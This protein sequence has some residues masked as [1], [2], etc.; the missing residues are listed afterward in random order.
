MLRVDT[1]AAPHPRLLSA[2]FSSGERIKNNSCRD[3]KMGGLKMKKS[4][5][6]LEIMIV[7]II[8]SVLATIGYPSFLNA[9]ESSKEKICETNLKT[10]KVSLDSYIMDHDAMPATL[11]QIPDDYFKRAYKEV[12]KEEGA[13][14]IRLARFIIG[15]NE[16][17]NAYAEPGLLETLAGG[18]RSLMVCPSSTS[19]E[20]SYGFND[21]L[22]NLTSQQYGRIANAEILVADCSSPTFAY[23]DNEEEMASR[24]T[25]RHYRYQLFQP[26]RLHANGIRRVDREPVK[27]YRL[28]GQGRTVHLQSSVS[29]SM[30]AE[31]LQA[32]STIED[33]NP[34]SQNNIDVDIK[35]DV[36]VKV[37]DKAD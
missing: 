25:A 18:N 21:K 31:V 15:I 5:T 26:P 4:F 14:K 37:K 9:L 12:L 1:E 6:M 7:I 17:G 3:L 30:P 19:A 36:K 29:A 8:L 23:S 20:R 32:H 34:N 2:G 22:A 13:W 28:A 35:P 24:L 27:I 11:S 16:I 10:L 33:K